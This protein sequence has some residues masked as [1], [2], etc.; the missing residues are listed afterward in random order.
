MNIV[1]EYAALAGQAMDLLEAAS[2]YSVDELCGAGYDALAA[3]QIA[4]LAQVYFGPAGARRKRAAAVESARA[5]RHTLNTLE[6]IEKAVGKLNN[7]RDG[8]A[9]R[10]ELC[11]QPADY[12]ALRTAAR[13]AV[14]RLNGPIDPEPAQVSA[15]VSNPAGTLDRTLHLRGPEH[16]VANIID[17]AR[18]LAARQNVGLAEAIFRLFEGGTGSTQAPVPKINITLPDY[19]RVIGGEEGDDI[20]LGAT[21]GARMTGAE[22]MQAT[23]ANHFECVLVDPVRGPISLGTGVRGGTKKQ[24]GLLEGELMCAEPGCS[25]PADRCQVA[26]IVAAARGGPTDLDNLT[27]LCSYHNGKNGT[28]TYYTKR[29]GAT[30][31]RWPGGREERAYHPVAHLATSQICVPV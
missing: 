12:Y 19:L 2:V 17:R 20:L 18:A 15:A 3:K 6:V 1:G 7:R 21:N 10:A 30:Y 9:L 29:G 25:T 28:R 31:R 14:A 5:Q 11:A 13:Q 16:R 8:W 23:L 4:R 26:H 24:R 27:L 22:F